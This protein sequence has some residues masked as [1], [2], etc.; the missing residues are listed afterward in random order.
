M[1]FDV[2]NAMPIGA[3]VAMLLSNSEYFLNNST[4]EMLLAFRDTMAIKQ[5]WSPI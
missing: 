4:P 1:V 5:G 3:E 2:T